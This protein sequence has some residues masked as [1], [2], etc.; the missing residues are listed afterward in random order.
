MWLPQPRILSLSTL[1]WFCSVHGS[2]I[3]WQEY[4]LLYNCALPFEVEIE[5]EAQWSI[6]KSSYVMFEAIDSWKSSVE[7]CSTFSQFWCSLFL[8]PIYLSIRQTLVFGLQRIQ[9]FYF[10][11]LC[12]L[13]KWCNLQCQI[14]IN[15]IKKRLLRIKSSIQIW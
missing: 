3:L 10:E 13:S 8:G 14:K 2:V 12:F 11:V 7:T 4:M 5:L 1:L 6:S 15:N 9:L